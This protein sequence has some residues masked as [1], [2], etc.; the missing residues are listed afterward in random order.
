[1]NGNM[2]S[3]LIKNGFVYYKEQLQKLDLLISDGLIVQI[4][5]INEN[6]EQTIDATGLVVLPGLVDIHVHLREPGYENKETIKTGT[7]AAAAG[8]FTTICCMPNLNPTTDSE[9]NIKY[10]LSLIKKDAIVNVLPY[11]S[12]TINE[13]GKNLVNF[14]K[15]SPYCFA[16]S[17]DGVGV[18]NKRFMEGAMIDARVLN[19][20]IVAHCEDKTLSA[21]ESEFRQ[22]ARDI[23]LARKINCHYHVC[24]ISTKESVNL[25]KLAKQNGANISCE[26]TPHHLL[27]CKDDI[28]NDGVFKM[29]PPLRSKTDQEALIQGIVDNTIDVIVTDHAPHT[30]EEK[31]QG[32]ENSPNGVVGLETSFALIYT[33]FVKNKFISFNRFID[34]MSTNACKLFKIDG[35][36]IELNKKAD[37][38]IANLQEQWTI[39]TTKFF[40][41]GKSTPFN[42]MPCFGKIKYTVVNGKIVYQE[43]LG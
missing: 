18:Q 1:M 29:N 42:N 2:N 3:L 13:E 9:E 41:K 25:I 16:F 15:L 22:I 31:S 37:L 40:S 11:A 26:V 43:K 5:I 14:K 30:Q 19:K 24:H 4:G 7:Q 36:A 32:Y 21:N 28:K 34:L 23:E 12:I 33:N 38:T 8:G 10:L 35:G 17:D 39:D 6:V 20:A 27:L